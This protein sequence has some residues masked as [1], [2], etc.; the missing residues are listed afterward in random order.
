MTFRPWF[1]FVAGVLLLALPQ[2]A[3]AQSQLD[4]DLCEAFGGDPN[5]ATDACTQ[6]IRSGKHNGTALA[7]AYMNR[8]H[9]FG[10]KQDTE[11]AIRDFNEA[12]SLNPESAQA[13]TNR[14]AMYARRKEYDRA[15]A[16]HSRAIELDRNQRDAWYNRGVVYE[17]KGDTQR[18]I[19]DYR[20]ALEVNP[21]DED[22]RNALR[23][24]E[25]KR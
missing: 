24:L 5:A 11:N 23:E 2:S 19:A 10:R 6:I 20:R 1:L 12:L 15:I 16:D 21:D 22:A 17:S 3:A 9:H 13:W 18:A 14:G 7:T 4:Y 25:S 8:G